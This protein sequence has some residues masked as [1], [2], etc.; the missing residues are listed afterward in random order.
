MQVRTLLA[1]RILHVATLLV[2]VVAL[3]AVLHDLPSGVRA[4]VVTLP[5]FTWFL[6][7]SYERSLVLANGLV[8]EDELKEAEREAVQLFR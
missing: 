8:D 7:L 4:V 2:V 6:G 5:V 1:N 3:F